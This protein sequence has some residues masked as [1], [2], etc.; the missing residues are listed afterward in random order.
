MLDAS[1]T[2]NGTAV[3]EPPFD[4][5]QQGSSTPA[6]QSGAA[7]SNAKFS[8]GTGGALLAVTTQAYESIKDP[9]EWAK[10]TGQAIHLS[11]MFGC[12][13][14]GQGYVIAMDAW[15]RRVPIIQYAHTYHFIE[16]KLSMRAD[17]MLARFREA[18]GRCEW[19][20]NG[21]DGKQA[22]ANWTVDGKKYTIGYTIEEAQLAGA[23][24]K[25]GS[26]WSKR[27]GEMLRA[28]CTSKAIRMLMPEVIS[29]VYCPEDFETGEDG[30]PARLKPD[31]V[32]MVP[33]ENVGN[34]PRIVHTTAQ[35]PVAA[36]APIVTPTA[37]VVASAPVNA[38]A[39]HVTTIRDLANKLAM[40]MDAY[41]AM[42]AKR[43]VASPAELTV[44]QAFALIKAM[45]EKL[46][47]KSATSAVAPI[48]TA[49]APAAPAAPESKL[50]M[51]I[52]PG[53]PGYITTSQAVRLSELRQALGMTDLQW[54]ESVLRKRGLNGTHELPEADAAVIIAKLEAKL[55]AA[56]PS[57]D[58]RAVLDA[59]K[60]AELTEWANGATLPKPQTGPQTAA[61]GPSNG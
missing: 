59:Q 51:P 48:V 43:G 10:V 26:N 35:A 38:F 40:P 3:E 47:A 20:H 61:P 29:G 49:P 1:N 6:G 8:T 53:S 52:V 45:S 31:T 42:L 32:G 30:Q 56:N 39:Q 44:E 9:V 2:G 28:R 34:V 21:E 55:A 46:I 16:G 7:Q 36:P 12:N 41:N 23:S 18:G 37:P 11:G 25:P 17:T 24:F 19:K 50:N 15:T 22:V 54:A 57:T 13:N 33:V 4:T 58:P 14:P 60:T 27:P 5:S